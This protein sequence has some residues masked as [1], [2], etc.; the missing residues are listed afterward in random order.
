[1]EQLVAVEVLLESEMMCQLVMK[2]LRNVIL[3]LVVEPQPVMEPE[4]EPAMAEDVEL[5]TEPE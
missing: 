1:M 4:P 2:K 3:E 5:D